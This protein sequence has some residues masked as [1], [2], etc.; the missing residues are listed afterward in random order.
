MKSRCRLL[1]C[2]LLVAG[3]SL[4]YLSSASAYVEA[5][6]AL[7]R[8]L[9]E[10]TNVVLMRV[11][12]VDKEKNLIIYRKVLDIKGKH[13]QDVIKHNIG[14]GG[15]RPNEWK[16]AMDWAEVGRTAVFFHNGGASETCI[17]TWWYQCYAQGEWWGHVHGEP[18]LLRS[19]AGQPEKLAAIIATMQAGQET[20]A[21]CMV[22]GDK[23]DLHNRRARIQRLKVSLK[24]LDYNPKRD[25]V[26]WGGE[27]FRRI[28]GM[29]G[30]SHYSPLSRID[31]PQAVSVIDFNGDGK[32]DVCLVGGGKV[33]LL[34]NGGDSMNEVP[35]PGI[36]GARA[37]VWADYNG[38]G[39][40]DLFL[41]T[42]TG[43][44][45]LTNLGGKFRDDSHMLPKEAFYNLT[46]A[47]WIDYNGDGK[48]DLLLA[49]AYHGLRLYRNIVGETKEPPPVSPIKFG[50]WHVLGPLDNTNN[51]AFATT[52]PL[53]RELGINL[54]A[55][56]D[57]KDAGKGGTAMSWKQ[58][59]F[60]D[61]KVNDLLRLFP[62]PQHQTVA[63]VLLYREIEAAQD[64]DLPASFGSDDSIVV[65]LNGV[66]TITNDVQRACA[67]DQESAVLKLKQGKNHLLIKICNGQ[68][69]WAFYF[70]PGKVELPGPRGPAFVDVSDEVGLGANG[71]CGSLKV[72][73]LTVCDVNGDGRPDI[74]VGAGTGMLLL[75]SLT[76]SPLPGGEGKGVRAGQP[77]FT[78]SKDHGLS[79]ATDKVG[80][81]F[82]D[83]NNDGFPD[84]FVPQ[85]VGSKLFRNDGKGHFTDVTAKTGDLAGNFG[86]ATSAAWGDFDNDG[87]L[88]LLVGCLKGPNRLFRNRGDGTFEDVSEKVGL[89]QRI[90]NSQAVAMVDLNNDGMLDMVCNNEGQESSILLGNLAFAGAGK[91]SPLT[92]T[93]AGKDGITGS[94]VWI[95]DKAGK[96][97]A[98]QQLLGGEGR[99][100][101][102]GNLARFV[103]EPGPYF[104]NV[105]YSTGLTRRREV[106]IAEGPMRAVIDEQTPKME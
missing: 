41:A 77:I 91:G 72:H 14:R 73:S 35:L 82:G 38:D 92:L 99:G 95:S 17:G 36:T 10:S 3:A 57:G 80:P 105:R 23:E 101:Q 16:Q 6:Y 103:L 60:P 66:R 26:G 50:K 1:I 20:I 5:P 86:W 47:A 84:L 85:K 32:P 33:L 46:S 30:F 18:F 11:E 70:Q 7:G 44:K 61:G 25:F 55:T 2:S 34:Q 90:F 106:Q 62:N 42:S 22:D 53:E 83:F 54:K 102:P 69:D 29:P 12:A 89:G 81:V 43:P 65:R 93:V 19:F 88:D 59:D 51:Q 21:P 15:L 31:E 63:G 74:L 27:D 97:I 64:M 56:Y 78:E 75:A 104:I 94:K 4:Y 98:A 37:A 96:P 100:G 87:K 9:L 45:L 24:L 39:L 40:P 49:N 79:F 8:V 58:E 52:R 71:L 13:P 28:S 68:G 76:P 67:P 48:P